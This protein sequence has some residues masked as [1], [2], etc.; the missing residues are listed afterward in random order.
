MSNLV[1]LTSESP[2]IQMSASSLHPSSSDYG[3]AF[4]LFSQRLPSPPFYFI[5]LLTVLSSREH[6]LSLFSLFGL[7]WTHPSTCR[8]RSVFSLSFSLPFSLIFHPSG[9]YKARRWSK[10]SSR[11]VYNNLHSLLWVQDTCGR[12]LFKP[13]CRPYSGFVVKTRLC[14]I[15]SSRQSR[16][17]IPDITP[18]QC[19]RF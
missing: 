1:L 13:P 14:R 2:F 8:R 17:S 9:P 12:Q 4:P 7:A 18:R 10:T 19:G 16:A 3:Q 15:W 11:K 6:W 5:S